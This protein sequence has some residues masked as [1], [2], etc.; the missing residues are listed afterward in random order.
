MIQYWKCD[1]GHRKEPA[2]A[3]STPSRKDL[4]EAYSEAARTASRLSMMGA[5]G[6]GVALAMAAVL[7]TRGGG[8]FATGSWLQMLLFAGG[9]SGGLAFTVLALRASRM[10]RECKRRLEGEPGHGQGKG[11]GGRR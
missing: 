3:G 9:L 5:L 6:F 11:R 2:T 8:F 10:A 4:E 7:M 1:R